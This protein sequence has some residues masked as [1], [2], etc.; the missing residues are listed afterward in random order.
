MSAKTSRIVLA[1]GI[2]AI[3]QSL[4]R[5]G[6][7]YA[8]YYGGAQLITPP[9]PA[10]VMQFINAFSLSL[11]ILGLAIVPGLLL[12]RAWGYWGTLAM[13]A[14]TIVFDAWAVATV[15]QTALMGLFIPIL[16]MV[17]LVPRHGRFVRR[18][19]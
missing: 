16:L 4:L 5:L 17:Y 3:V 1:L 10:Y 7:F 12:S 18:I 2:L 8:F 14:L 11:G 19:G 9:P 13:A 6:F 15:A